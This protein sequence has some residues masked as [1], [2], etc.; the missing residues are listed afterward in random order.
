MS[1]KNSDQVAKGFIGGV[2]I[3]AALG[4]W[5]YQLYHYLRWGAWVDGSVIAA[6][7]LTSGKLASWADFPTDWVGLHTA[8]SYVPLALLAAITGALMSEP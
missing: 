4:W 2:L 8:L 1:A 3:L 7:K 5:G 6:L